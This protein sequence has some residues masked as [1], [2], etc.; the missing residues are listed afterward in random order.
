MRRG[1]LSRKR[2]TMSKDKPSA[3]RDAIPPPPPALEAD[4]E[5]P[6]RDPKVVWNKDGISP[7][8]DANGRQRKGR[9]EIDPA[10]IPWDRSTPAPDLGKAPLVE[11]LIVERS[12][13]NGAFRYRHGMAVDPS[14]LRDIQLDEGW[15]SGVVSRA[16]NGMT[17]GIA[18]ERF[19][20][21]L[22]ARLGMATLVEPVE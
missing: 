2:G 14:V 20:R 9:N 7:I 10:T 19:R 5:N 11:I 22:V 4:L 17:M 8:R 18:V 16:N 13:T 6:R 15:D 1:T 12:R 21:A 3:R